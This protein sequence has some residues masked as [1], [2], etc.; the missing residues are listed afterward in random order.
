MSCIA[1]HT[2]LVVKPKFMCPTYSE[3]R[4]TKTLEFGAEKGLLIKRTLTKK[5]GDVSRIHLTDWPRCKVFKGSIL[6]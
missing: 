5:M 4:Q 2:I 1:H 3:P 6:G